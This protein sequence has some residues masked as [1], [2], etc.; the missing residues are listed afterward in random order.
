M[1]STITTAPSTIIPKSNAPNERRL[2]G[3]LAQIEPNRSE[4]QG[5]RNGEGDDEGGANIAQKQKQD[6]RDQDHSLA[7]VVQH[8]VQRE[9]KQIAAV[10]HGNELHA[11]GQD[12]IIELLHLCREFRRAWALPPRPFSIS[13]LP[14]MTSGSSTITPSGRWVARAMCPNRILGPI[15]TTAMSLTRIAVPF[16]V[17]KTVF[18]ISCKLR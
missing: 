14:W 6:D 17:V 15:S 10:Q 8:R 13:T 4:Q 1:F 11:F 5:K 7:Q 3:I 12:A 2:A 16:F 9:M 18:S